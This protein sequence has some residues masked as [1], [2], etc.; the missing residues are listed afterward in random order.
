MDELIY[1]LDVGTTKICALI[2][3]LDENSVP[4]VIGVGRVPA[5][6]LRRG[7][8]VN[9]TEATAAIG[10]AIEQAEASAG[11]ITMESAY[12][13][14]TGAHI[15]ALSSKG[16]IAIGR[17]GRRITQEDCQR[18]LDQAR[19]IAMPH[20]REIINVVARSYTVDG[21]SGIQNPVGMF[22]YRLEVD[23]NVITGATSAI[24]N[25]A[26][27]VQAHGLDID[28]LV[29]EPLASGEAVLTRAER[30]AGVAVVDIG[31]GTT[32]MA[33]YLDS[34]LW[35]T[36]ILN[37]GGDHF[38]RDVALGLRMPYDKAEALI[39]QFGH[40]IPEE[41]PADAEVRIPSFGE[42]GHQVIYRRALA[43]IIYYRAEELIDLITDEIKRSGYD[44]L[45]PAGIVFTG[46]VARL[47]G[48]NELARARL[49]WPVRIG[50][51]NGLGRS[52]VEL[53]HPEYATAVGLLLWGAQRG[54]EPR[55]EITKAG[56][57]WQKIVEYLKRLIAN[58]A[59]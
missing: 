8:V 20:N 3:R 39:H 6:G 25:L 51:P 31:G 33:I 9:T 56:S 49:A 50:I 48:L 7:M 21:E 28:D 45:L 14:I 47:S 4:R 23:A 57:T 5:R 40:A 11:G 18:A 24:A 37:I 16:T 29:L 19:T 32:D 38:V 13:G 36:Q 58:L 46:G 2:A 54:T 27:C 59:P 35:H 43:E 15:A 53:N 22:G 1:A 34:A 10:Q 12:V 41:V 42:S 30:Q 55:A 52:A 26:N 44:G 17:N